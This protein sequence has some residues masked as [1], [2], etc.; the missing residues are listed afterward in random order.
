MTYGGKGKTTEWGTPRDVFKALDDEFHFTLDPCAADWN[1]K[2]LKYYT[3]ETDG[4]T[5]SWKGEVVFMNPPYGKDVINKWVQKAYMESLAGTVIVCLLPV[6]TDT[7]WFQDYIYHKAEIR[8]PRGRINFVDE[9][10]M[11]GKGTN[12]CSMFVIYNKN[13]L[14]S[15]CGV[16]LTRG[17]Q[18][19]GRVPMCDECDKK[20]MEAD[21]DWY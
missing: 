8:F 2:C 9:N 3:K 7:G 6:N 12:H 17:I 14:C 21:V 20:Q 4:L 13:R 16:L 11:V 18:W 10:G 19:L 1:H 5:K 15:R